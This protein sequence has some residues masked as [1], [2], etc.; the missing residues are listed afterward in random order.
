MKISIVTAVRNNHR[1]IEGVLASVAGQRGAE[2]EHI[3]MDGGSTDGT[4]EILE[5]HR[6]QIASLASGLDSGL[7]DALNKGIARSSGEVIGLLNGDD[8]YAHDQVLARVTAAFAD[9][10]VD[11]VYGD[12]TY[13]RYDAPEQVVRHWRSGVFK[14]SR[15]RW[16]WMPP[17]PTLFVRSALHERVGGYD[18]RYRIAADY[19]YMLRLL[20]GGARC[21]YLPEVLVRM[22]TGG[23]SNG[24]V[25]GLLQKSRE[26]LSAMHR[27]GVGGLES[28]LAKNFRK[29]PQFLFKSA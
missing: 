23:V 28:L 14:P 10:Q 26:D 8:M 1:T 7:Y 22:R 13:V 9:P 12:L 29:L 5:R 15:L 2:V 11:A 21:R 19:D 3:V 25:G 24:S 16:G 17:H 20:R 18:L 6:G 27:H 4:L